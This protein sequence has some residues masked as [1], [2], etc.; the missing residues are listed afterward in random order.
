MTVSY[1]G[2][3]LHSAGGDYYHGTRRT[4]TTTEHR[5]WPAFRP[6][7]RTVTASPTTTRTRSRVADD[8]Q[9]FNLSL[10]VTRYAH[11]KGEHA[12]KIG[13]LYERIGN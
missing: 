1:L 6:T 10:D 5:T 2:Y 4:F 11:W 7:S 13:G 3:G 12:F 9:R 8:Y